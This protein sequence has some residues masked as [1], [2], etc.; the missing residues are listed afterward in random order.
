MAVKST[1][2]ILDPEVKS[3]LD[4]MIRAGRATIDQMVEY[5]QE[6]LGD[7]AP[8]RSAV[9]RYVK[10]INDVLGIYKTSMEAAGVLQREV[11]ERPESDMGQA[12]IDILRMV[13]FGTSIRMANSGEDPE[14]KAMALAARSIKDLSQAEKIMTDSILRVRQETAKQAADRAETVAKRNGL[15]AETVADLKRQILGVAA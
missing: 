8:S 5:L 12:A 11:G 13:L 15:S 10:N 6:R 3:G 1:V 9:G 7:A 2:T 4:K 14:P